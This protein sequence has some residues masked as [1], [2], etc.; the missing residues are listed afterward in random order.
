MQANICALKIVF[1]S[2]I[3]AKEASVERRELGLGALVSLHEKLHGTQERVC[4]WNR[5]LGRHWPLR[6]VVTDSRNVFVDGNTATG[7]NGSVGQSIKT[8]TT[9]TAAP[10]KKTL[11]PPTVSIQIPPES[12]P[13]TPTAR[14]AVD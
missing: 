13:R 9:Y 14:V 10:T 6:D 2:R 4:L 5:A 8:P 11:E 3:S 12:A 7:C 1:V